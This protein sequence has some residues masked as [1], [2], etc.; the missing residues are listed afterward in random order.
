MI[1]DAFV[2]DGVAHPFNFTPKNAYGSAGEMFTQPLSAS[3]T[4][5]TPEDE[6]KQTAEEFL[7]EWT[8]DDI[9]HMVYDESDTDMLVAMPLPLTDLFRD[10]LSPWETCADLA[11]AIPTAPSSGA[12]STPSR[13][14]RHSTSWSGRSASSGRRRSSSTTCATTT[15][16]RSR[17]GW[18]TR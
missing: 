10:G 17:G 18:T 15:A 3:H 11:R 8:P 13:D 2:F 9:R 4:V 7:K 1:G 6:P 5:L 14:A 12:R 16:H